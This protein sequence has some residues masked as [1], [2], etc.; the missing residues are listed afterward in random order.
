MINFFNKSTG[1]GGSGDGSSLNVFVQ[2][3]EPEKKKGVWLKKNATPEAYTFDEEVFIGGE[4]E[5][6]GKYANIPYSPIYESAVA[7]NTDIY[8]FGGRANGSATNKAY[9][10]NT[11][12]NTWSSL[13]NIPYTFDLGCVVAVGTDIYILGGNT[14]STYNYKYDTLTDTYTQM[15]NIPYSFYSGAAVAIGTDIYILGG[16]SSSTTYK[17]NYKYNTLTDTYT[18][19]TNIPRDFYLGSSTTSSIGTDIYLIIGYDGV[20]KYNTLTD[21]YSSKLASTNSSYTTNSISIETDI[22]CFTSNTFYI[23]N[24]L[25]NTFS[26]SHSI[27]NTIQSNA[28]VVLVGQFI[29]V[30]GTL[31]SSNKVQVYALESKTYEQDNLVVISQGKYNNVGYEIEL[32]NNSKDVTSPKYAFADAWYYTLEG[33]LETDIPTYYGNGT[34]WIKI[35]N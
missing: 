35:K 34:E 11:L 1:G 30:F 10:Y 21:T 26:N 16:G 27:T 9:K 12:T 31:N 24:T 23:Y 17:Y 6:D 18:K 22:Y 13:R 33:G 28:P 20:Y 15:T 25:T 7:I 14:Y 32:Y 19:M 3:Q 8:L 29:Y 5:P 2:L 4:W